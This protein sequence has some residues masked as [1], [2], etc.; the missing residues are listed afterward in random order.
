MTAT[1]APWGLTRMTERLPADPSPYAAFRLDS[2]TQITN[3]YDAHGAII[4]MGKDSTSST[5]QTITTSK[6]GGGDGSGGS[7]P[8]ADD[9]TNDHR[10]D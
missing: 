10:S 9:S 8:M 4:D 3:F 7:S 1:A 5:Y 6:G 2:D